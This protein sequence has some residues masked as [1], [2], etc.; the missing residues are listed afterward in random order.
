MEDI[1]TRNGVGHVF[2]WTFSALGHTFPIVVALTLGA[3]WRFLGIAGTF[4][5][6]RMHLFERWTD[7]FVV[8]V[9]ATIV[10]MYSI[11]NK[12]K[13][14][15]RLKPEDVIS[16]VVK[17]EHDVHELAYGSWFTVLRGFTLRSHDGANDLG[18]PL[19]WSRLC[20]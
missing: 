1:H 6:Y 18:F 14:R 2:G 10:F 17:P 9:I 19:P 3:F 11:S 15:R 20:C 13:A 7:Y 12:Q 16:G 5:G 4:D 8:I